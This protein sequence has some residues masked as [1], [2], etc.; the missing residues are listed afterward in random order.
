M[1]SV[2]L[3]SGG[4]GSGMKVTIT[5]EEDLVAVAASVPAKTTLPILSEVI[6]HWRG[7]P[8]GI[9]DPELQPFAQEA[10]MD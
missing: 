9:A 1:V 10:V 2:S 8:G 5:R 6:P 7:M 4:D 3:P